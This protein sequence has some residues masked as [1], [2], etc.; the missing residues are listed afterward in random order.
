MNYGI[1]VRPNFVKVG[2]YLPVDEFNA[3]E[4]EI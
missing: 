1:F 3:E 2:N 4:D